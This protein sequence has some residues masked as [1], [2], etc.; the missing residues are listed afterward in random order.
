MGL[1]TRELE[2]EVSKDVSVVDQSDPRSVINLVSDRTRAAMLHV[3]RTYPHYLNKSEHELLKLLK[4]SE[5]DDKVRLLFWIEYNRAQDSNTKMV[6]SHTY[7]KVMSRDCF[8]DLLKVPRRV[9]WIMSPPE[10]Y[11][12]SLEASLNHGR[13]NMD[14]IMRMSLF[15][16]KGKLRT[17]EAKVFLKAFELLDNRVKGAVVQRI[18]QKTA[19]L[20]LHQSDVGMDALKELEKLRQQQEGMLEIETAKTFDEG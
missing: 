14:K 4:P 2:V 8:F 5:I 6:M 11:M 10:E 15:D 13:R 7:S 3:V 19:S 1:T 9:A 12:I 18:E 20:H 16:E 17:A